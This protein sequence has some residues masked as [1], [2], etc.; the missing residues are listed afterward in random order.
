[1]MKRINKNSKFTIEPFSFIFILSYLDKNINK[2]FLVRIYNKTS[3]I[4]L[5]ILFLGP[6]WEAG[7]KT[8]PYLL[9]V[10]Y[11]QNCF[12]KYRKK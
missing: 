10:L 2:F 5:L 7:K 3:K 9:L 6:T 11:F 1:M 12:L 4:N 8:M